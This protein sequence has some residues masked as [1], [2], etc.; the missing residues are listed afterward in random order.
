MEFRIG[1]ALAGMEA[2]Y[3]DP[4]FWTVHH[5]SVPSKGTEEHHETR[6]KYRN[7]GL[8]AQTVQPVFTPG[9][10]APKKLQIGRAAGDKHGTVMK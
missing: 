4:G 6:Q 8:S 3:A 5:E 2:R 1:R 7:A 10:P 9:L